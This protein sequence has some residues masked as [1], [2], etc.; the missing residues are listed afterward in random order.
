[1]SETHKWMVLCGEEMVQT[2]DPRAQPSALVQITGVS[3]IWQSV[4]IKSPVTCNRITN[5]TGPHLNP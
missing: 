1:M 4:I 5:G 2:P 3:A